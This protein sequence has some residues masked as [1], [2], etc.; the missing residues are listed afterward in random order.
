MIYDVTQLRKDINNITLYMGERKQ[1]GFFSYAEYK[2][3]HVTLESGWIDFSNEKF[4]VAVNGKD[5]DYTNLA[6]SSFTAI[7]IMKLA[8]Q[9]E[10]L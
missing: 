10:E 4:K 1:R 3:L 5:I 6:A 7:H 2:D 8:L 9:I